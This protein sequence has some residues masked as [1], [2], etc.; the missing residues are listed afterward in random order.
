MLCGF[1][2]WSSKPTPSNDGG[3]PPPP[4]EDIGVPLS[5]RVGGHAADDGDMGSSLFLNVFSVGG[6]LVSCLQFLFRC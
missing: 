2:R 5:G 3:G 1:P 4:I 6:R